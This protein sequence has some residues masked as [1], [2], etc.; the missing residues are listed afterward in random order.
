MIAPKFSLRILL[1]LI[2]GIAVL[3]LLGRFAVQG[4]QWAIAMLMSVGLVALMFF[5]YIWSFFIAL[6]CS[7]FEG[8]FRRAPAPTTPFA[9]SEPPPQVL[10]PPTPE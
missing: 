3:S 10:P 5:H 9:T 8:I 7:L 6:I 4:Q 2:T 1:A